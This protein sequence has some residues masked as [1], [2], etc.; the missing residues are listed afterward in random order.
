MFVPTA[1]AIQPYVE[2]GGVRFGM[3]PSEVEAAIGA[4]TRI[5][6]N[7]LGER[8]EVRRGLSVRYDK[9]LGRV[10]EIAIHKS[11][12][13]I[14]R[15]IDLFRASDPLRILAQDDP[16]PLESLGFVVFFGLGL[17]LTGFHDNDESQKAVTAF[18][19]GRWDAVRPSMT[20][21]SV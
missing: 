9:R 21:V 2:V 4:A 7:S 20:P 8:D 14:Y 6:T 3:T 12:Q 15:G 18:S 11:E 16:N 5:T 17:A 19:A 10:A 1:Y 13:A